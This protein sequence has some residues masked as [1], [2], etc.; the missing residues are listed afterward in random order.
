MLNQKR[1]PGSALRRIIPIS[2]EP[3]KVQIR[4][5]GKQNQTTGEEVESER[6]LIIQRQNGSF[7]IL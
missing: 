1:P 7:P 5:E 4:I 3:A 6:G 2:G